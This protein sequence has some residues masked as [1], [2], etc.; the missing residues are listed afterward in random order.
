MNNKE[1]ITEIIEDLEQDYN[2][3]W[4]KHKAA[5]ITRYKVIEYK[6]MMS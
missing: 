6:N 5:K 3:E 4:P 1:I 2:I